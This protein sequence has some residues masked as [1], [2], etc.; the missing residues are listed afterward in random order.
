MTY[1]P[2]A[3]KW[4]PKS[5]ADLV[6]Q[7][8]IVTPLQNAL[9]QNKLHHA[10]LFTGTRG[11][12]KTTIARIFAKALNCQS[13]VVAEPC[14][15][16]ENCLAIDN[17]QFFDLIEVDGASRTRVE[18]TRELVENIHYAPTAGRF[19]IFIIDEVHMLSTH[20]FNALL[21]TLEEPP[22]HVKFLFATTDPQKLPAT[23]LSRCLQFNLSPL[24]DD[25]ISKQLAHI[26]DTEQCQYTDDALKLIAKK[27]CGSMRD[28]LTLTEQLTSALPDGL[29][30]EAVSENLGYA[31]EHWASQLLIALASQNT[32]EIFNLT[33]E[34]AKQNLSYQNLIHHCMLLLHECAIFKVLD[35]QTQAKNFITQC[36]QTWTEADIHQL[37]LMLEKYSQQLDW[38]P[39]PVV[40]LQMQLFRMCYYLKL[41]QSEQSEPL[42]KSEKKNLK[43]LTPS[44]SSPIVE[45]VKSPK[46]NV[47]SSDKWSEIVQSI[48]L[49]GLAK[50]ALN[51]TVFKEKNGTVLTLGISNNYRTLLTS[52]IHERIEASLS[53]FYEETI[54]IRFENSSDDSTPATL[55][56]E[57]KHQSHTKLK[58]DIEHHS[59]V[60]RILN[61]CQGEIVENSMTKITND[62]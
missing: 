4:R 3:R 59:L 44:P 45:T 57:Q 50:S 34:I 15:T 25:E 19:K 48:A 56:A 31:V 20:S 60:N 42:L 46:L 39:T 49:E 5:F 26:L 62:L 53:A 35:N 23:F 58:Q 6:G 32:Q 47:V 9:K 29:I 16:C 13:G 55:Q 27:A 11:V 38:V 61:E 1:L 52:S 24:T 2:L 18:D 28:A 30:S 14:L 37:Y 36:C 40:G 22:L 12:G 43:I 8:H 10:Y 54:K 17:G 21:K 33:Q 41:T 51:H 7:E